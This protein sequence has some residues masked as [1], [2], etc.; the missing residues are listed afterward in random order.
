MKSGIYPKCASIEIYMHK[1]KI[2]GS[3]QGQWLIAKRGMLKPKIAW[4]EHYACANCNYLESYVAQDIYSM[5]NIKEE[6]LPINEKRKRKND[7]G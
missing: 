1:D 2:Y 5:Q 7:E 4:L 6:W 3:N